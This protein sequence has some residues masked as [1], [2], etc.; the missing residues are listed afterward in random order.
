MKIYRSSFELLAGEIYL[1]VEHKA[2]KI[3]NDITRRTK[4]TPYIR[5]AYFKK[6]EY[7]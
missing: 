1:D 3:H 5:S 4:R 6:A 7:I 2:R